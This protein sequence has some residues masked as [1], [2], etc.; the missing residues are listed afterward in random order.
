MH[1]NRKNLL[2]ERVRVCVCVC[3]CVCVFLFACLW[4]R[5]VIYIIPM[6]KNLT[7]YNRRNL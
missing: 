4:V 5:L 1:G 7:R 2:R 6:A 3:V